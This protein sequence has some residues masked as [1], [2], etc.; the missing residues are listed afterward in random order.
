VAHKTLGQFQQFYNHPRNRIV[1]YQHDDNSR[2]SDSCSF[3]WRR[4]NKAVVIASA[5]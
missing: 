4:D 1:A 5:Y 2:F 3:R